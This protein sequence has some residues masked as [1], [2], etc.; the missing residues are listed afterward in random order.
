LQILLVSPR[1]EFPD[2]TPRWLRIP[3]LSLLILK[4][5]TPFEFH[6]TIVEEELSPVPLDKDWD[7]VGITVMTATAFHAYRLADEFRKRGVRVVLGGMHVSMMPQEAMNHCDA[8]VVGEAEGVWNK[9]LRDMQSGRL[10]CLYSNLQ[11]NIS[12]IP[13][14]PY[15]NKR[16]F[17]MP[18]VAPLVASRGCPN[19]CEFCCVHKVYGRRLRLLPVERVLEQIRLSGKA[20]VAFLDDNLGADRDWALKLFA[21][22][23]RLSI[24][25]IT[26][27]AVAFLLDD[28]LFSAAVAAGLK[29]A[30]VGIETIDQKALSH[31]RKSVALEAYVQ[32]I[33]RSRD[34]GVMLHMAL[35]FGFD[36][37][38]NSIFN[39]TFDF[40]MEQ[41]VFSVSSYV[42]TPFPG[43]ALYE[44]FLQQK[45]LLHQNW[46]Y[47]DGVTPVFRPARMTVEE[48]AEEYMHFRERLFGVRGILQRLPAQIS[49]SPVTFLGVAMGFRRTTALL[50]RH[51]R[52]YFKWLFERGNLPEYQ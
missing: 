33:R 16:R 14:V 36:E 24:R 51:Y 4:S 49:L 19:G 41:K 52:R 17:L 30:F 1:S 37:H 47:Y 42:L 44:R 32:A 39:R 15:K 50:K 8:V 7:L 27:V 6:V 26:Q 38:D 35:I 23:K 13:L 3:Q 29:G 18:A 31:L 34:S 25:F 12:D 45:R 40:I 22:L 48:L 21:G 5:L 2:V 20:Y 11:P 28:E 10:Q 9:V 46:A 43:T